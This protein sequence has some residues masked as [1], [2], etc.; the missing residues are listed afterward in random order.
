LLRVVVIAYD[1]VPMKTA[2]CVV[3]LCASVA[4][5]QADFEQQ[6]PACGYV[7]PGPCGATGDPE[8]VSRRLPT[9]VGNTIATVDTQ[10]AAGMPCS[11][12]QYARI[13]AT[14]P[15]SVPIGGPMPSSPF[16]GSRLWI[17]VPP[18]ATWASLCWDF[19]L[20]DN[21]PQ[22]AFN[23]GMSLDF[24]GGCSGGTLA[25][26]AYADAFSPSPGV[27]ADFGSPCASVGWELFPA[28]PQ[29]V[30]GAAVPAG[31][32]HVCVTVWNGGDDFASSHGVIDHVQFGSGPAPCALGLSS[33]AGAGSILIV[34]TP[35]PQTAG[36][37]FFVAAT[38]NAGAFPNGWFFGIDIG[39][40]ELAAEINAGFPF[41]GIL[42]AIGTASAGPFT[43]LPSG[44]VIHVIDT[45]WNP[46]ALLLVRNPPVA[47]TIP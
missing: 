45:D 11:G 15:L 46:P 21:P 25:N 1:V 24:V 27:I 47:Y 4:C 30:F 44:L 5:G 37:L 41:V 10:N 17:P 2:F 36:A 35:C 40:P 12:N 22:T 13:V 39:F 33:P 43:G 29:S 32:T 7:F 20:V 3:F 42:D 16:L 38:L 31:A 18:G 9:F 34:H 23:D 6:A 8:N 28:G 26:I 19:Y 14:G